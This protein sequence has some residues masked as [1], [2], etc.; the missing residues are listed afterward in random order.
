[1]TRE[2]IIEKVNTLLA[3][4]FEV[5]ASTL[6]PDANVKETL[7]LDSLSLVDLVALIQ[8]TYQVKIPVSDLRQ[9]QTFTD[10]YDYI[11]SHLP[12]A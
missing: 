3:E 10:L 7:S 12:A 11:E 5:E 8:Q 1:M 6:T 9:I 2:E 4:E